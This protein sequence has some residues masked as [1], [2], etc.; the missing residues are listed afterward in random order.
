MRNAFRLVAL[1]AVVATPLAAQGPGEPM[2]NRGMGPGAAPPPA[3]RFLLAHTGELNLTDAQVVKLAAIERRAEA[4]R[5][6]TRTAMDSMRARFMAQGMPADSAARAARHNVMMSTMQ[7]NQT[8]MREGQQ[9]DLREAVAV[10]TADQQAKVW[11]LMAQAGRANRAARPGRAAAMRPRAQMRRPGMGQQM[12]PGMGQ[13]M[14]PGM[15]QGVGPGMGQRP[16]VE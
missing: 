14:G 1:L 11:Q 13:G 3:A 10:L 2:M 9:A 16:P 7:A 12:R 6:T 5:V 15:G 8:K 4:R